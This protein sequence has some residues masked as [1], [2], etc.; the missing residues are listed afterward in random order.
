MP[1][2]KNSKENKSK[3]NLIKKNLTKILKKTNKSRDSKINNKKTKST[4]KRNS[5]NIRGD[6]QNNHKKGKYNKQHKNFVQKGGNYDIESNTHRILGGGVEDESCPKGQFCIST[7]MKNIFVFLIFVVISG[8]LWMYASGKNTYSTLFVSNPSSQP[9][10]HVSPGVI[11]NPSLSGNGVTLSE[12]ETIGENGMV[13]THPRQV[14]RHAQRRLSDI[15]LAPERSNPRMSPFSIDVSQVGVPI[16]EPTRGESGPYQQVG[17]LQAEGEKIL[18]LFGRQVYPGSNKWTYYT[19][20]DQYHQVKVPIKINN[21]D[22]TGE[23]GCDEIYGDSKVDV[24]AYPNRD[25]KATIYSLDAPRY[26]PFV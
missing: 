5:K 2:S 16:N 4:S 17:Y 9:E 12:L 14:Y 22:C 13:E 26:I 10:V 3:Q 20:T 11:I 8:L 25:F 1:S 19:S 7:T 21:K 23:Y 6:T 15:L 24:P 18:P